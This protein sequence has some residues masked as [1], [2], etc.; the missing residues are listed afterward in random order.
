MDA[1]RKEGLR[2]WST[3]RPLLIH[4]GLLKATGLGKDVQTIY[5]GLAMGGRGLSEAT[6]VGSK[7][8]S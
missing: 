1:V 6:W 3:V 7:S 2:S 4:R 5:S 8:S